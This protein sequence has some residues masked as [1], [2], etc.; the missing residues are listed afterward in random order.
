M[1]LAKL[2]NTPLGSEKHDGKIS[3][4]I[5]LPACGGGALVVVVVVI[6]TIIIIKWKCHSRTRRFVRIT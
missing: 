2:C 5:L 1:V 6:V 3:L 4:V